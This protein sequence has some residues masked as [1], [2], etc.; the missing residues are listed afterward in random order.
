VQMGVHDINLYGLLGITARPVNI[1]N[2]SGL[3]AANILTKCAVDSYP[4]FPFL[5]ILIYFFGCIYVIFDSLPL[6][7]L[8][9]EEGLEDGNNALESGQVRAE[10]VLDLGLVAAELGIKVLAVGAGAHGGGE[11]GLDHEAV[12]GLKGG[13][14]GG[15]ERVGE[16]LGRVGLV[17]GEGERGEFKTTDQPEETLS[18]GVLLGLELV[19]AE[20]LD[21]LR[22]GGGGQLTLTELLD[23]AEDIGLDRTKGHG[24]EIKHGGQGLG[25]V[26]EL[27]GG[28]G[29]AVG[30]VDGDIGERRLGGRDPGLAG[31][32]RHDGYLVGFVWR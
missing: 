27:S 1:A 26:E 23:V 17:G 6:G 31:G 18:G 3:I 13:S 16:L 29:F 28:N 20:I 32:D 30:L 9:L 25:S 24:Q 19:A 10:V 15:A 12:V 4:V 11:E 2:G 7:V 8:G 5:F 21:V 14:V 22:L